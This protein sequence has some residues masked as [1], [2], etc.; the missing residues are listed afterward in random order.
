MTGC[1][2]NTVVERWQIATS[3]S[4]SL[5]H[6]CRSVRTL[7]RCDLAAIASSTEH[8]KWQLSAMA[9]HPAIEIQGYWNKLRD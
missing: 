1:S 4:T 8:V 3:F 7:C 2:Q 5:L 9:S 6:F